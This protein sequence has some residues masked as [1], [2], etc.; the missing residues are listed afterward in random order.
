MN[1]AEF[2]ARFGGSLRTKHLSKRPDPISVPA[3]SG[4][5]KEMIRLCPWEAEYL[6]NVASTARLGILET[7]RYKGGSTFL[8]ACAA[9]DVPIYSIDIAPKDDA[10][11]GKMFA[12]H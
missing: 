11:L 7:G 5:P 12:D 3:Q 9:P 1:Y 8:L 6:W 10:A 4:L 2:Y